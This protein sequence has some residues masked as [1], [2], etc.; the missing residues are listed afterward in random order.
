MTETFPFELRDYGLGALTLAVVVTT[1][2]CS[3]AQVV[4]KPL[5]AY[6]SDYGY[7]TSNHAAHRDAGRIRIA[8]T[9]SGGG[10]RAAALAYGV[11]QELRET[12]ITVDGE[13]VSLLDEVDVISSVS[14]GSVPAAHYGLR[15][16]AI[17]D[18]VATALKLKDVTVDRLIEV[19][20]RLLREATD[21]QAFLAAYH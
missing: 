7:Q 2:G 9:L 8:L 12:T 1:D 11:M 14:G 6:S 16:D 3:A 5:D 21:F 13:K 18:N 17:F 10:T 4:N 19:G 15:G 20:G